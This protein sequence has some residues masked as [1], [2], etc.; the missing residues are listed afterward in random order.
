MCKEDSPPSLSQSPTLSRSGAANFTPFTPRILTPNVNR[1]TAVVVGV[2][3]LDTN[4]QGRQRTEGVQFPG[5][6][7]RPSPPLLVQ[8]L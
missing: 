2:S 6:G 7:T 5:R 4:A 8:N 1:S 3:A